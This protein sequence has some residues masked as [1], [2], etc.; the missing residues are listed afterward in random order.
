MR[1]HASDERTA[2]VFVKDSQ[3]MSTH[4]VVSY[5][6]FVIIVLLL[7]KPIGVYLNRVFSGDRTILDPLLSP[8]ERRIYRLLRVDPQ[9]DMHWT[10]YTF[11][12]LAFGLVSTLL[13]FLLLRVQHVL[14]FYK[15]S[16][17]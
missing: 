2:F 17:M 8:L 3:N 12:F 15:P 1:I 11:A 9:W 10:D 13:G 14:P 7:A 4:S 5:L 16:V 6:L